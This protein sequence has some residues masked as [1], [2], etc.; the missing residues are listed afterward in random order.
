[1]DRNMNELA[2][3][4]R[5]NLASVRAWLRREGVAAPHPDPL[6]ARHSDPEWLRAHSLF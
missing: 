4:M 6:E 1:M 3:V 5:T 2:Q